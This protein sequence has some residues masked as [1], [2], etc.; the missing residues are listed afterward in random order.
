[1]KDTLKRLT[2]KKFILA[3]ALLT[4]TSNAA[5][6]QEDEPELMEA[7]VE[8]VMS[9][10]AQCK[11]DASDDEITIAEMNN[12]LLTCIN[13]ELEASDYKS[14]TALPEAS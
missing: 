7:P 14:I 6:S 9:L 4:L 11:I 10:L 8:Y 1:M 13:D 2:M 12:Y 3:L 5:Y